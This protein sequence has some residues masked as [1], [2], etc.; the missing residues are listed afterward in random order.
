MHKLISSISNEE[1]ISQQ[2]N[3]SLYVLKRGAIKQ[4]VSIIDVRR[5]H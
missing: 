3:Q 4:I 5:C 2:G 1:T